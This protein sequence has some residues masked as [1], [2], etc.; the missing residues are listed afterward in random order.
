MASW[1]DTDSSSV[2]LR[3]R[4]RPALRCAN[5][6]AEARKRSLQSKMGVGLGTTYC[7][8]YNVQH[9]VLTLEGPSCGAGQTE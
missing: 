3:M 2:V 4:M 1:G 9:H 8:M 7:T 6:A 5:P